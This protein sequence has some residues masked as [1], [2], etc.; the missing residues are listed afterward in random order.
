MSV[1]Y[2]IEISDDGRMLKLLTGDG[3]FPR[4]FVDWHRQITYQKDCPLDIPPHT[5]TIDKPLRPSAASTNA[6]NTTHTVYATTE[7]LHGQ[8]I[9]KVNTMIQTP[10]ELVRWKSNHY[11]GRLDALPFNNAVLDV[12]IHPWP[13]L[14]DLAPISGHAFFPLDPD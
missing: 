6:H 12:Y 8:Q 2:Q 5:T 10:V 11:S 1:M 3:N 14:P 9:S 4:Q 7:K 13:T